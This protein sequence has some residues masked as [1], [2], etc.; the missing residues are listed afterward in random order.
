MK[1]LAVG[2]SVSVLASL[3]AQVFKSATELVTVP[4]SVTQRQSDGAL[5]PL[6]ASDF[7]IFEDGVAQTI[8]GFDHAPRPVSLC[9]LLLSSPSMEADRRLMARF[10]IEAAIADIA[11]RDEVALITFAQ[12]SRDALPWTKAGDIPPV[13]WDD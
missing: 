4:V 9:I 6:S 5:A 1:T 10:A 3:E 7:R 2:V 11:P 13:R 8:T 12:G